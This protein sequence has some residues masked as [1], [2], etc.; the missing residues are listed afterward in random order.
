M[1]SLFIACKVRAK[2][3]NSLYLQCRVSF[4]FT[5]ATVCRWRAAHSIHFLAP[6]S[7]VVPNLQ[8]N[9]MSWSPSQVQLFWECT[10]IQAFDHIWVDFQWRSA[11]QPTSILC[12]AFSALNGAP[13]T[14]IT[15]A[16]HDEHFRYWY[17]ASYAK[18]CLGHHISVKWPSSVSIFMLVP[19]FCSIISVLHYWQIHIFQALMIVNSAIVSIIC[20]EMHSFSFDGSFLSYN[21]DLSLLTNSESHFGLSLC[22]P[23]SLDT[24]YFQL[25]EIGIQ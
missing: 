12:A 6:S 15:S 10:L 17:S 23:K 1:F 5:N 22:V 11:V 9:S 4:Q 3:S 21:V 13:Q 14:E 25:S 2:H 18:T 19:R 20:S 16:L 8:R 24:F 7:S